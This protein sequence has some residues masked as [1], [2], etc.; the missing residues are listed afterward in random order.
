VTES[1]AEQNQ[2]QILQFLTTEHFVLQTA[3]AATIQEANWRA[4]LFLTSVSSATIALA[5]IAQVTQMGQP[6][7]LFCLIVLPCLYFIGLVTFVRAIQVG[8]EDMVHARGMARIRHY[9]VE[10]APAMQRYLVH[11][12]HDSEEAAL[13]ADVGLRPIRWQS[14]MSTA[15]M[16]NVINAAIAGVFTGVMA[17]QVF[18]LNEAIDVVLGVLVFAVSVVL[19]SRYQARAWG[20]AEREMVTLFPAPT[21]GR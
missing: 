18:G 4:S 1:Q 10:I 8:I 20:V 6:F 12:T 11:S 21:G 7:G 17:R 15:G 13:F 16:V 3:R 5:F 9:Y 2:Q 19:F 14:F